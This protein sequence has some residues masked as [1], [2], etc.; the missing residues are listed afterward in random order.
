MDAYGL[1][2][3]MVVTLLVGIL[4]GYPVAFVL[5]GVSVVFLFLSDL[6]L[7]FLGTLVSRVY[8]NVIGNWLLVAVPMFVFMGIVLGKS[9]MARN[10]LLSLQ[11]LLGGKPGGIAIA[12]IALGVLLAASTGVIGAAVVTLGIL[13]LP[14][15]LQ[16][17]YRKEIATGVIASSGTLGVLIP[18]SIMLVLMGDVLSVSVGRLF[19]STVVPGLFLALL[20]VALVVMFAIVRPD[21]MPAAPMDGHEKGF[22]LLVRLLR[23]L[24]APVLLAV[25]VLGSIVAGIATPTEAAS[26]GAFGATVLALATGQMSWSILKEAVSQTGQLTAMIMFVVIG[27]TCFGAVFARL[28]G[29]SMIQDIVGAFPFGA[30]G[31][32]IVLLAT[33]FV[34]GFVLEW[35]EICYI[36]L[37]LYAPIVVALDFGLGLGPGETL[38]WFAVLVAIV[39]QTS[40]LTPPVGYALFYLKGAAPADVSMGDIYRGIVPFVIMQ[41]FAAAI[42]MVFPSFALWLPTLAFG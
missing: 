37:P 10:L 24:I 27:A 12:V 40:F 13:S 6:P 34:I 26:M 25:V 3:G 17:G 35:I 4:I 20:Y 30:Y 29:Q 32:L 38:L 16:Q 5:A 9:G 8:G 42:V 19:V 33:I 41:L 2:V 36:I 18:P 39:L 14:V 31:T 7:A 11:I 15:M 21:W 28:G 22:R 1:A 23:D